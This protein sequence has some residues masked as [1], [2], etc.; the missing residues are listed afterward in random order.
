MGETASGL[1]LHSSSEHETKFVL[2][3][4]AATGVVQWLR[5]RCWEDPEFP[6]GMVSSIY[7][8]RQGWSFLREKIN[9]DYLKTKIRLRWYA[10]IE[11]EEPEGESYLEAKFKT[12]SRREKIR[13][14]TAFSGKWLGQVNLDDPRLLSIPG[15]LRSRG[16]VI[17]GGLY[18][19]FLI[20]YKRR[21]FVEPVTGA[22][23]CLDY[24]L[25]V[26]QVNHQ[27]LGYHNPFRLRKAAFE[28]KG[29]LSELPEVLQQ[30]TA[31]GCRKQSFSKYS[32][33][34]ARIMR[35]EF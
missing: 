15:L 16:V 29:A 14:R 8:D 30:L 27:M 10:D 31:L 20:R 5:C 35:T 28:L 18:P 26:P 21:R 7:Y 17:R 12:G 25:C 13:V 11:G 33:C 3:N 22:R 9:S 6:A 24:D 19:A 4:S 34:Y 32:S 23:L 1:G 2:D